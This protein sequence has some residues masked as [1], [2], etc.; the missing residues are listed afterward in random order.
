M[1][2][3]IFGWIVLIGS[4]VSG[5]YV[6]AWLMFI[7]PI[8]EACK[9]FDA[10]TLTGLMVGTTALKCVFASLVGWIIVYVGSVVAQRL[11]DTGHANYRRRNNKRRKY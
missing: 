7:K 10:G 2:R 6:G 9:A 3:T 4:M 1:K 8:I 5:V 11:F